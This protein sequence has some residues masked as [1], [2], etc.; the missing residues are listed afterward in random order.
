ME[1]GTWEEHDV[2]FGRQGK[3][4]KGFKKLGAMVLALRTMCYGHFYK[5]R[6]A[7]QEEGNCD[8]HLAFI[9]TRNQHAYS[10]LSR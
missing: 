6:G 5:E 7:D 8:S 1:P 3:I 9:S 2:D 10:G 4:S